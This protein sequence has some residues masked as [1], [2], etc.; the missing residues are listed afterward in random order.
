M[1]L[2]DIFSSFLYN[3]GM[4]NLKI[5]RKQAKLSQGELENYLDFPHTLIQFLEREERPFRQEHIEKLCYF[6]DVSVDYLLGKKE[7]GIHV[8]LNDD[9]LHDAEFTTTEVLDDSEQSVEISIV[10]CGVQKMNIGGKQITLPS[11]RI[12]RIV[13]SKQ[14]GRIIMLSDDEKAQL[15]R[16]IESMSKEDSE[17][18]L[19][20][21]KEFL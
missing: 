19:K 13:R 7:R 9:C 5:L 11:K 16:K 18:V 1:N 6:F 20:F 2:F 17:K 14:G 15:Y 12:K 10:D 4:N 8:Y 21:I 3:Q